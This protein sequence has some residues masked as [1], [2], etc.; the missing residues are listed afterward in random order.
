M[1]T[2]AETAAA[3]RSAL[4]RAASE[5]LDEGGA[6]MVTLRGVGARAGVSRGA[7]YGHFA[8]KE[9]LLATL[10]IAAWDSLAAEVEQ[11][12]AGPGDPGAGLESAVMA[13]IARARE[14]PHLYA[15]MFAT[16]AEDDEAAQAARRLQDG[17]LDLVGDLVGTTDATRYGALLMS[18][19]HGIAE[20]ERSGHLG[21][22]KWQVNSEQL[23][24]MAIEGIR[25]GARG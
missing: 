8:N 25:L 17:F 10:A 3:T 19:A 7:P 13:L 5:L 9:Q 2:R 12:R 21:V 6:A 4:L 16:P 23:V 24:R 15:L 14:R 22:E 18:T 20:L 11:L 1:A